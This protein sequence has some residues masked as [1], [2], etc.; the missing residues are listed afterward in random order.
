MKDFPKL[1]GESQESAVRKT[2]LAELQAD[3][4]FPGICLRLHGAQQRGWA[5]L[6]LMRSQGKPDG[7]AGTE[8]DQRA[9]ASKQIYST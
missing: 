1:S 9:T 4:A 7:S 8:K 6:L 5:L 2:V 3:K